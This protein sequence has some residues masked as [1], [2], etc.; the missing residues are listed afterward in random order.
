MKTI[1]YIDTKRAAAAVLRAWRDMEW[2]LEEAGE[3]LATISDRLYSLPGMN[4]TTPVQGGG[5]AR[6]ASLCTMIDA[7]AQAEISLQEARE[8]FE[9]VFPAW[10]QLS[11][12]ER[13]LLELRYV[14][15][16]EGSGI[17][18]VME[19]FSVEKSAAYNISNEAL[20]HFA[21]LIF[22]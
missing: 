14:D 19:H 21:R 6:E 22:W 20:E 17:R 4:T 18:R 9:Q 12:R 13:E 15:G 10:Q 11:A 8:Y 1:S 3:S 5:N 7:K 16:C 2:K